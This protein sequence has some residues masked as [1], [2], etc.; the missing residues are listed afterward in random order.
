MPVRGLLRALLVHD[1]RQAAQVVETALAACGQRV[2]IFADLVQPVVSALYD[3]WYRGEVDVADEHWAIEVLAA[4]ARGLPPTTTLDP[5][6]PGCHVVLAGLDCEEH[7]IGM[8]LLAMALQDEG[9]EVALLGPRTSAATL[10]EAVAG[11][12]PRV[13]GLSASYL[14]EPRLLAET[15]SALKAQRTRVLVGGQAFTRV[16]GLWRRVGADS[17]GVD[18]R[19]GVVMARG[20][21]R[22]SGARA[23][24][25][26]AGAG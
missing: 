12:R 6:P 11:Y 16:N 15:V 19:A 13:V 5:V 17:Y 8:E 23:T 9:W 24:L 7:S 4:T 20:L 18:A 21:M 1:E 3:L 22:T 25:A 26:P 10:H 14:P 2:T